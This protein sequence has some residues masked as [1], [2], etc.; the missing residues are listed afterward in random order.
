MFKSKSNFD[1][2]KSIPVSYKILGVVCSVAVTFFGVYL[3]VRAGNIDSPALPSND[4]GRMYTLEQIYQKLYT[5]TA[6]TKQSGGFTEP[7]SA[8]GSTM[9]T[10]DNIYNDFGTDVTAT[11]GTTAADV[12][13]GKTFFATSGTTRGADWGPVAGTIANCAAD[14]GGTCYVSNASKSALDT[15][16][17]AGNIKSGATI[18]G[19]AGTMYPGSTLSTGQVTSYAT[20]DDGTS[21]KGLALSYTDNSNGTVT[22]N[23]TGLMWVKQPELIIPGAALAGISTNQIQ[24]ARGDWATSTA[25]ALGDLVRDA[26]G[27]NATAMNITNVTTANPAVV[28]VDN[29]Q[30][31]TTGQSVLIN[32][33]TWSSGSGLNGNIYYVLVNATAKTLTLYSN[34]LLST[35]V[36]NTATYGSGGT[37]IQTKFYVCSTA[38]TS[39]TFT[40]DI[41]NWLETV[42]TASAA[43][44]T[45]AST[46]AWLP[47][48]GSAD[49]I[50]NCENLT[51]AG[52][53]DWRLPNVKELFNIVIEA[54][55]AITGVKSAGAPYINQIKFPNTVSYNYWSSTTNPNNTTNAFGVNFSFGYASY[56]TKTNAYY[57]RCVRGQ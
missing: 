50:N 51:Y 54:P 34:A 1:S 47:A 29:L 20:N 12:R 22:D 26:T 17:V 46:M 42:W 11:S 6:A 2:F 24:V 55:D 14:N 31:V 37:A 21:Q 57:V 36:N 43:N 8:P 44:L 4:S 27:A 10:L 33:I 41:A 38:H 25:Y 16:L 3:F 48:G 30:G 28:T 39:G 40:D 19:V 45:T 35:A 23:N 53:T 13:S 32:N 56:N 9:H 49:A 18:F 52:Y 5:G 7:G 15:N